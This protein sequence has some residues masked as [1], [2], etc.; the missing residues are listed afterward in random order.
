MRQSRDRLTWPARARPD[1]WS[2]RAALRRPLRLPW[3]PGDT[4]VPSVRPFAHT[5]AWPFT[6]LAAIPGGGG[7]VSPSQGW[8]PS[9]AWPA[10][11]SLT[12]ALGVEP[13][14]A[15][16]CHLGCKCKRLFKMVPPPPPR[17]FFRRER[18]PE[19]CS[20]GKGG[21]RKW[22]WGHRQ[23]AP[24]WPQAVVRRPAAAGS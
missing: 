12:A 20:W 11:G 13:G 9:T 24:W 22:G 1:G 7:P 19:G 17:P 2:G 23:R 15:R 3:L 16:G 6:P 5:R 4:A 10:P 8:P 14:L 21:G 18:P